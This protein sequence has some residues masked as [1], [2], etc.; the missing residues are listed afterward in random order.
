AVVASL[1]PPATAAADL[2]D[3][4][5]E[6]DVVIIA[7]PAGHRGAAEAAIDAGASVVSVSDDVDDVR[8]LLGMDAE[9]RERNRHIVVGAGFAPGLACLLAAHGA[10]I[11]RARSALSGSRSG[12]G[13]V[14]SRPTGSSVRSTDRRWQPERWRRWPPAGPPTAA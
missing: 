11:P 2:L 6:A 1:G 7:T 10:P 5:R 9:A 8:A 12:A 14:R 13:R 4:V 3:A